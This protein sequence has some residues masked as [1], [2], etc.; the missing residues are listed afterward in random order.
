MLTKGRY[1]SASYYVLLPFLILVSQI[2][3]AEGRIVTKLNVTTGMSSESNYFLTPDNGDPLSSDKERSILSY[4]IKPGVKFGYTT[5]K[6][7]LLFTYAV[8]ANWYNEKGTP[9][10]GTLRANNLNYVGQDLDFSADTQI[11]DRLKLKISDLYIVTRN[12]DQLDYYSNEKIRHQYSKNSVTP[13]LL[14]QFGDKFSFRTAYKY[15]NI[16]YR[17]DDVDEDSIE[18]RGIFTL[19]YNLNSLNSLD[20]QYQYWKKSYDKTS[21]D[22]TS[23]QGLMIFNRELKYYTIALQGGYH[24]RQFDNELQEDMDGYVWSVSITADRPALL[25]SV[26]QNYNDTSIDNQYYLATRF[27]GSIGHLFLERLKIQ[28]DGY[29]QYSDYLNNPDGREDDTSSL[30]CKVTYLR[31]EMLSIGFE[32]GVENRDSSVPDEDYK[33]VYALLEIK[34]N[35]DFGSK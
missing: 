33:N 10:P 27:T 1:G 23:H 24:L 8:G 3:Y 7:N 21:P 30:S 22:Y 20:I 12:P 34:L 6:S 5:P 14:Y 28:L 16:D 25:L 17:N 4:Y 32:A 31:N 35:Y 18:N 29:Y 9:P 15:T 26:S 19:N 2:A 11:S 13:E